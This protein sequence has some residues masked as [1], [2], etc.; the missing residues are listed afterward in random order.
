[1]IS[2]VDAETPLWY[3]N[4]DLES[5]VT[6]V[7]VESLH[8]LLV[9]TG[10]DRDETQFLIKGFSEG[11]DIG[12]QGDTCVKCTVPN[13]KLRVGSPTILWNKI[14][15][16]VQLKCFVGLFK[17]V[18]FEHFIQSLV[19]LVPKD[20]G[21]Q[22]RLIF[23]LSYPR[24][25]SSV[26]SET[27][28]DLTTVKYCNFADAILEYIKAGQSCKLSKYDMSSAFR[29]LGV[30]RKHWPLLIIM[31]VS[32]FDQKKYYFIDKCLPFG[33][34]ISCSHFQRFSNAI[35]HIHRVKTGGFCSL[36]YLDDFLFVAMLK[37]TCDGLVN[38]ISQDM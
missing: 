14:M 27:P 6:P 4:Y 17:E 10:Y 1:M 38:T 7:R 16:E 11:F 34:A 31:A 25:G 19:G 24:N 28:K 22:T 13:L 3:T 20:N 12:Y 26:N 18:P 8:N 36:N 37:E 32:P 2:V 30:L 35:A 9:E 5:I 23:H 15:K 21:K 33:V 29:Q